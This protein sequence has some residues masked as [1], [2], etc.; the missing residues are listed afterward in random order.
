LVACGPVA[1]GSGDGSVSGDASGLADASTTCTDNADCNGGV[2]LLGECC[3]HVLQVCGTRCCGAEEVCFASA[4]V[5]PGE[6]CSSTADCDPGWY[7]ETALGPGEGGDLGEFP[8]CIH[9]TPVLGRCVA[10]PLR[11][12]DPTYDPQGGE[13]CIPDCEY[14]PDPDAPLRAEVKWQWGPVADTEP[15]LTDVWSTPAVGRLTDT[16]CDGVVNAL[17]PPAVVVVSGNARSTCC[18]CGGYTPSTC[19]TGVLRALD[20]LTGQEIWSL[21][22]ASAGSI[23]FAGVSVAL[24]DFD[25]DGFLEIAA[26]TGEGLLAVVDATGMVTA[27]SEQ[28][29]D[30]HTV[31]TFGWGGGLAVADM[32]GD[33][34][35]EVAFGRSVFTLSPGAVTHRFTGTGGLGGLAASS[36]LSHFANLDADDAGDLEL[37]AGNTAYR[38]DG[39]V[40]WTSA[41]LPDGFTAVGDLE[42]GGAPEVVLVASG[43][44]WVLD[45]ATGTVRLGPLT[46][47]GTGNGGPP[48]L[49]D[50]DGDGAPE[51]GV[52]QQ[53]VYSVLEADL[54]A[55]TLTVLWQAANHDL[56][57]S[58]T[59]STVFDFEGDGKAEVIYNDECFLWVYDGATGAVRFATPTTS[60]TATEASLVADLD[61]DGHAEMLM[62]SNGADPSS[63]GWKCDIAPW[64]EPD[65]VTG[66]PA[67]TPPSYG[68]AYRG[69][70][71]FGDSATSWVGTRT[72]WN[73]HAYHVTNI[74]D[75]RDSA[76]EPG[77]IYGEIPARERSNWSQPWLNNFRQNVQDRGLFDAPDAAVTLTVT[78]ASPPELLA[79]VRNLGAALLPAGVEVGFFVVEGGTERLLQT[80]ATAG[81]LFPGQVA[82]LAYTT[83]AAE[84]FTATTLFLAR[85][86]VD[87]ANPRFHECREDNNASAAVQA[88]CVD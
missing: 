42:P 53:N 1:T 59:G 31:G 86:L 46:L 40:L 9:P 85:I 55:G 50:F 22:Q 71:V 19:L 58:V 36:A 3:A 38:A 35:P 77:S 68:P 51:I 30:G 2:C 45:G 56:S 34:L 7:C 80:V 41:A 12:D 62:V 76:C 25:R 20:G 21:R 10:L 14:H 8:T 66:R 81:P 64:N 84:G 65:P 72:L 60:F 23:G 6:L 24:G 33:G 83:E 18:S 39:T 69:I 49:A 52:A 5:A 43:Q 63:A 44:V 61:G 28:P 11:C 16:N 29:V 17:D 70:T 82:T 4:C 13:P 26:V 15:E 37:L 67:W 27:V 87:P 32:D 48:T 57:S 79:Y 75:P 88:T 47:G 73:Q 74:C 54:D 78:C